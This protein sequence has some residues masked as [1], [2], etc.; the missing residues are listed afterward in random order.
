MKKIVLADQASLANQLEISK[1]TV[2]SLTDE[3]LREIE[4]GAAAGAHLSCFSMTC[5]GPVNDA[6]EA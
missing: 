2:A 6:A 3:Q 5:N 4:G 1:E